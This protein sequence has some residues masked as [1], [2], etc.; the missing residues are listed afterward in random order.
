MYSSI[1]QECKNCEFWTAGMCSC[2]GV[3]TKNVRNEDKDSKT[4]KPTVTQKVTYIY[5]SGNDSCEFWVC[6][7]SFAHS[8]QG[9]SRANAVHE[10]QEPQS[11]KATGID[12]LEN[13]LVGDKEIKINE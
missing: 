9:G 7:Y 5:K 13:E 8:E 1:K 4:S 10:P 2:P 11:E 6:S 12:V 3:L